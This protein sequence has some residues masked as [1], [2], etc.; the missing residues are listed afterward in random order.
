MMV[1]TVVETMSRLG[2]VQHVSATT[3]LQEVRGRS[4]TTFTKFGFF[5][6]T[7][8]P[9]LVN[10]VYERPLI[11][12]WVLSP[13]YLTT[14]GRAS[15]SQRLIN[16][17]LYQEILLLQKFNDIGGKVLKSKKISLQPQKKV[18]PF[19]SF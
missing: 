8:P 11:V 1:E 9:P 6:T 3:I 15:V 12:N 7:Y 2:I 10:V 18:R 4:Q 14:F 19:F 17:S 5:L 16:Q 13:I